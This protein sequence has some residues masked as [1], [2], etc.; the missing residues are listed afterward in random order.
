MLRQF[1]RRAELHFFHPTLLFLKTASHARR[2]G[3]ARYGDRAY[4]TPHPEK[5]F[6]SQLTFLNSHIMIQKTTIATSFNATAT[7]PL[8]P[9]AKYGPFRPQIPV[10]VPLWL[11]MI[12]K[13]QGK[14]NVIPPRWLDVATLNTVIE[15]ERS[16][17]VFQ[18]SQCRTRHGMSRR[19]PSF[20]K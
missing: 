14:C 16:D 4:Y 18:V 20:E 5:G 3:E 17:D 9:C 15:A 19:S 6:V 2:N 11:A 7:W 12:L 1:L 10:G 8:R 13:K